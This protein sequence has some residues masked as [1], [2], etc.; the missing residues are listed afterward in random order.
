M[1]EEELVSLLGRELSSVESDNFD[2]YLESATENLESLLCMSL[3]LQGESPSPESR[4]YMA[5]EGYR[6]L[7]VDPFTYLDS[8]TI[9]GEAEAV[10]YSQYG[11]TGTWY[12]VIEFEEA[13]GTPDDNSIEITATWGFTELPATLKLLLAQMFKLV[14]KKQSQRV[15]SK[16]NEGFSVTYFDTS[17]FDQFV[18][19]NYSVISRYQICDKL[20]VIL[21]GE[22]R[23]DGREYI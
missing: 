18:L 21:H 3:Y 12:N 19:D 16:T 22:T 10:T 20:M 17:D 23:K 13:L 2:L 11:K 9:N 7:Y 6:N 1:T 14:S 5:R 4:L 8:V 15:K